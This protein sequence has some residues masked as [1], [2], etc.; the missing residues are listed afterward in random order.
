VK[1]RHN[2]NSDVLIRSTGCACTKLCMSAFHLPNGACATSTSS[3][4]LGPQ[5]VSVLFVTS[6]ENRSR[7]LL[8]ALG[9]SVR[10]SDCKTIW[11]G[12]EQRTYSKV[13]F[14]FSL[15]CDTKLDSAHVHRRSAFNGHH[16]PFSIR[17]AVCVSCRTSPCNSLV[18]DENHVAKCATPSEQT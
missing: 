18:V 11:T 5:A 1:L 13:S 6:S 8:A 9:C 16:S 12:V 10:S 15:L 3:L 4:L 2:D 17:S 7:T 14:S